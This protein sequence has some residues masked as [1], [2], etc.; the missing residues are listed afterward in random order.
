MK[1][2]LLDVVAWDLCMDAKRNIALAANPY[3]IE[4]DVSSSCQTLAGEVRQDTT[5][6]IPL[7]KDVFQ[8][9]YPIAL[10]KEDLV[11]EANRVPEVNGAV[12]YLD[13]ITKRTVTGQVQV[14]TDYGTVIVS[15]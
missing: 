3:A 10:L 11:T 4:Q 14:Q 2:L 12:V 8:N 6:G 1:T 13:A 5:R 15:L 7:W 9:V